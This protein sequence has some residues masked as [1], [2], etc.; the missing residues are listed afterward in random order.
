MVEGRRLIC[1]P[2]LCL[3]TAT[4]LLPHPPTHPPAAA[5]I[6]EAWAG[7]FNGLSKEKAEAYLKPYAASLLDF[8]EAIYNDKAGQDDGEWRRGGG[9]GGGGSKV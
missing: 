3:L 1:L 8:A 2:G 4:A 6:L 9:G 5:G 7:M